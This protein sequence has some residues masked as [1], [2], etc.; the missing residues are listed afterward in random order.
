M[1]AM[2]TLKSTPV[3]NLTASIDFWLWDDRPLGWVTGI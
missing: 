3:P 2:S 1:K